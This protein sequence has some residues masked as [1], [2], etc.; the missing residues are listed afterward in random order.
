M[1]RR[2]RTYVLATVVSAVMV[3]A[4]I[5]PA[6]AGSVSGSLTC[7]SYRF[8]QIWSR[9]S[10]NVW[11]SWKNG[12]VFQYY[13]PYREYKQT[14]TGYTSTWWVVEWTFEKD[15]AGAFCET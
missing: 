13:A 15:G 14:H 2:G 12:H 3:L 10:V 7:S 4:S 5:G 6:L 8:V 11:H 1:A 9:A